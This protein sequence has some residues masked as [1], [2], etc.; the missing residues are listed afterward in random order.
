MRKAKKFYLVTLR[1][2]RGLSQRDLADRIGLSPSTI[3]QY[4]LGNRKP[5]LKNA[6]TIASFFDVPVENIDFD[7]S[8]K[9]G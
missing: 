6:L 9:K 7:R 5:S 8:F 2:S 1:Q 3:A 4:E